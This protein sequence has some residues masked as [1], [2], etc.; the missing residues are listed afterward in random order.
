MYNPADGGKAPL[1]ETERAESIKG[2][3]KEINHANTR[4]HGKVLD[5]KPKVL[6]TPVAGATPVLPF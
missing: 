6:Y 3:T 4:F 2:L 1:I 5:S